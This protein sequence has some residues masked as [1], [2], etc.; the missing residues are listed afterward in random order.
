[1]RDQYNIIPVTMAAIIHVAIAASLVLAFDF[2]SREFPVV[3]LAINAT[4]VTEDELQAAPPVEL[5]EPEPDPEPEL[6]PEPEP[7]PEPEPDPEPDTSEQDRLRQEEEKRQADLRAE[8]E[9]IREQQERDRQRRE[10]EEQEQRERAEAE[11]ERQR[12]LAEQKRQDDLERQRLEN[13]RQRQ[14]AE[15][16]ERQRLRQAEIDAE[17]QRLARMQADDVT[18][19]QYA[20]QQKITRNFVL[21]ASAPATGLECVVNVR[22]LPGGRVVDVRV[23]RCNGD[24]VVERAI[25]AAVNKASPLPSPDNPNIFERDLQIVFKPEQ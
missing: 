23:G 12:Q 16:A 2:R 22:Q 5:P 25:E 17:A 15:A 4:L 6:V 24:A 18:R 9:R 7:E 21:P 1:M 14:E 10:Q 8:Q 3:P 13:E 19:W 11:V 20:I